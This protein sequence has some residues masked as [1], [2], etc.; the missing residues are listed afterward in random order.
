N[1][2]L[3]CIP[4]ELCR[5]RTMLEYM[6]HYSLNRFGLINKFKAMFCSVCTTP[7]T[8]EQ[9]HCVFSFSFQISTSALESFLVQKKVVTSGTGTLTTTTCTPQMSRKLSLIYSAKQASRCR[10]Y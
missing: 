6:S 3:R 5:R 8:D 10:K 7:Y 2:V 1:M 9:Y 4:T